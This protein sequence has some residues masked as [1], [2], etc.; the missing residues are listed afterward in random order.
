VS[1]GG[2]VTGRKLGFEPGT[3][4]AEIRNM[5]ALADSYNSEPK[6]SVDILHQ[7]FV[8]FDG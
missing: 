8:V 3:S 5:A 7:M 2:K 4:R 6:L 1:V